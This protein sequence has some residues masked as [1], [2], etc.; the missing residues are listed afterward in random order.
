MTKKSRRVLHNLPFRFEEKSV[1]LSQLFLSLA[2]LVGLIFIAYSNTFDVP[3][4]L[5]DLAWIVENSRIHLKELSL[6]GL[7]SSIILDDLIHSRP[8]S[9]ISLTL[10]YYYFNI[11]PAGWH[12]FNLAIHILSAIILF[13]L[14]HLT[15]T[16][17]RFNIERRLSLV[18]ALF[19]S[20]VWALHPIQTQ[21]VTYVIQRMTS[22]S[23]MFYL[24]AFL[25]YVLGSRSNK[26]W[27]SIL[28]YTLC[29]V[30]WL[31]SVGSKEI[32]V[33]LPFALLLYEYFLGDGDNR[34]KRRIKSLG[35]IS[36]AF[37]LVGT[38][39]LIQI[40]PRFASDFDG[41]RN[42]TLGERLLTEPR[43][44][45]YYISQITLPL[46]SKLNL[47]HDFIISTSLTQPVTTLISMIFFF[48]LL[49]LSLFLLKKRTLY[50]FALF[51]FIG[52]LLIES[53]ILPVEIAFDHRL[54]LPSV[55][56]IAVAV[57][58]CLLNFN[59]RLTWLLM[60]FFCFFLLIITYN[61]NEL[62]RD[63]VALNRDIV[64]KSPEKTRA[65]VNLSHALRESGDHNGAIAAAKKAIEAKHTTLV[66]FKAAAY[67]A[68]GRVLAP[69]KK[70][71]EA[72]TALNKSLELYDRNPKAWLTLG[73][74]DIDEG[75]FD[76]AIRNLAVAAGV[77]PENYRVWGGLAAAAFYANRYDDAVIWARR[78]LELNPDDAVSLATLGNVSFARS[79]FGEA[80]R[81]YS[82]AIAKGRITE[83]VLNMRVKCWV[84]MGDYKRARKELE[85]LLQ[86]YPD[87]K[88]FRETLCE[89][90]KV[91]GLP[92]LMQ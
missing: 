38:V 66:E 45:F 70:F 12:A 92:C 14:I 86:L 69:Q 61:R 47:E 53:T 41:V 82:E 80:E 88:T 74:L 84:E 48:I 85:M 51:W 33:T 75:K 15:L 58:A 50:V 29:L 6:S 90:N 22:M 63:P 71:Q 56:L 68:L 43:V 91:M 4:Y 67:L 87:I 13:F 18:V 3:F 17:Q 60:L 83:E 28:G 55:G 64:L 31:F 52:H 27:Q 19:T 16:G 76:Q 79:H 40:W 65:W 11:E 25:A 23:V 62:W 37:L 9:Q 8:I 26:K 32:S 54:Y 2:I 10:N 78:S 46:S 36:L 57:P 89:V 39:V 1:Q 34:S 81:F 5:D 72:R 35:L 73:L 49:G 24:A 77:I 20:L 30:L 44:F 42:F 21:T 59:K 7:F